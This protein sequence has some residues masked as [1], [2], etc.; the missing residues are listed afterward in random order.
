[1]A[2][3]TA[4]HLVPC[5][6]LGV[7]VFGSGCV[8]EPE[9][10]VAIVE[11]AS[12]STDASSFPA[13]YAR[14]WMTNLANCVQGDGISPPVAARTY[15]YGAIAIYESVVHGMPGYRSL[16][17][18]VNGLDALPLPDAGATYDWPTVLAATMG[19]VTLATYVFPLRVFFEFTTTSEAPIRALP[20]A[21]IG[22]RRTAG[23]P[24]PVIESSVDYGKRLGQALAAWIDSDGYHAVRFK[25]WI[26]PKGPDKWVP[27]GF[28]DDD[29]VA[30]PAEPGFGTLRG[31][32]LDSPD[33]CRPAGPPAFSTDPGSEFYQSAY[34]MWQIDKNL[35]DEQRDIARFW[36]D[37]P[38]ETGTPPAHWL[39]LATK[40]LRATNLAEAAHGYALASLGHYDAFIASWQ[41]KYE[42]NLLR[43]QTYIR[44]HIDPD[45]RPL[46]GTPQFP[47]YVSGHSTVSGAADVLMTAAFGSGPVV[48]DTKVRR[49][50]LPRHYASFTEAANEAGMSRLYGGIHYDFD[51]DDGLDVGR[52][53][54]QK[55]L[56]RV[57]FR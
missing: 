14:Q 13:T 47:A 1:M 4:R 51:N 57:A 2:I 42:H 10:P 48:D 24:E 36:A 11:Q 43:P 29:K 30:N 53:V 6:A 45:F 56:Q 17:G 28:S 16:V 39:A 44:R 41:T 12:S 33:E 19:E 9:E 54:G 55:A 50:Y 32:V 38:V 25:G 35:T 5:V 52:C 34:E 37:G 20:T 15:S 31:L 40:Y 49:G 46:L 8:A 26:P 23:V 7:T 3:R 22:Y 21:Q 18:Q 27:T